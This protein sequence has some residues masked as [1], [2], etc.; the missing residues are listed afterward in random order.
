MGW[1]HGSILSRPSELLMRDLMQSILTYLSLEMNWPFPLQI[2]YCLFVFHLWYLGH[3]TLWRVYFIQTFQLGKP[4]RYVSCKSWESDRWFFFSEEMRFWSSFRSFEHSRDL[5]S[6][7]A[8]GTLSLDH[9]ATENVINQSTNISQDSNL[10]IQW[11]HGCDKLEGSEV[12]SKG[13]GFGD[14]HKYVWSLVLLLMSHV[15]LTES[16]KFTS[17]CCSVCKLGKVTTSS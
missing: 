17:L 1:I 8:V 3:S 15:S 5:S 11:G 14:I 13:M 10:R 7:L 12:Q 6:N 4:S 16:F 9:I 2:W